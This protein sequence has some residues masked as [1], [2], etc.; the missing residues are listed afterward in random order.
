MKFRHFEGRDRKSMLFLAGRGFDDEASEGASL[1]V[2]GLPT[3]SSTGSVLPLVKMRGGAA[4]AARR[5]ARSSF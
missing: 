2:V 3:C 5:P 4:T 1:M